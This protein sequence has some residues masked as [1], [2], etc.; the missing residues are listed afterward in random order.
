MIEI[1]QKMPE[2]LTYEQGVHVFLKLILVV[3]LRMMRLIF[4]MQSSIHQKGY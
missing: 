3:L 1:T 2:A 4:K